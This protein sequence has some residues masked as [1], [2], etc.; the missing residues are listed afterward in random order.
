MILVDTT[1]GAVT[2]TI[3]TAWITRANTFMGIKDVG[4]T[5]HTNNLTIQTE[6]SETIRSE[7]HTSELQSH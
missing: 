1:D 6:N 4:G 3:P 7:E 5:L 2:L